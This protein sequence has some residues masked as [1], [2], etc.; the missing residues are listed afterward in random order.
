MLQDEKGAALQPDS[1]QEIDVLRYCDVDC[2]S[3]VLN[4]N[5]DAN[6]MERDSGVL[7]TRLGEGG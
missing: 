3:T 4:P 7:L 5:I 6:T 1:S 2:P